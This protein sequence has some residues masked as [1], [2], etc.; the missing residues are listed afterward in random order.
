MAEPQYIEIKT[1]YID[2]GDARDLIAK[3]SILGLITANR[4]SKP[5]KQ[6][7]DASGI[8]WAEQVSRE[9]LRFEPNPDDRPHTPD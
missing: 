2:A 8:A 7:L 6:L 4:I 5:A 9:N 3:G 1:R